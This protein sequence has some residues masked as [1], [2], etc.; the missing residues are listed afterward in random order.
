MCFFFKYQDRIIF[1]KFRLLFLANFVENTRRNVG[2][3]CVFRLISKKNNS[4]ILIKPNSVLVLTK[5]HTLK[6]GFQYADIEPL[7]IVDTG[8]ERL[9]D[10]QTILMM[11]NKNRNVYL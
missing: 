7:I 4:K 2:Y 9:E 8:M 3:V 10:N 11:K 6:I 5:K 1:N